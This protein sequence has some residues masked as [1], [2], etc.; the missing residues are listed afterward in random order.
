M[1]DEA[2]LIER[3][4]AGDA[5]AFEALVSPHLEVANRVAVT[6]VR[7]RVEA[8]DVVQNALIK[9]H[10][11]LTQ[12]DRSCAFRPWF[13]TITMN[14]ARNSLRAAG[15]R[16]RL[17]AKVVAQPTSQV[18]SSAEDRALQDLE[19][20]GLRAVISG[21]S[22][23]DRAVIEARFLSE[24]SEA[25]TAS[26]LGI[27]VGTV[28][29]RTS[30]AVRRLQV[31]MTLLVI[32]IVLFAIPGVRH[33]VA[34][35]LG[36]RGVRIEPQPVPTT[37]HAGTTVP[38]TGT[39]VPRAGS[40]TTGVPTTLRPLGFGSP[41]SIEAARSSVPFAF[42]VLQDVDLGAPDAV[43][44]DRSIADGV[45][46]LVWKP[47]PS[48]GIPASPALPDVG[49][50]F[51]AFRGSVD[52]A[53]FVKMLPPGTTVESVVVGGDRGFWIAGEPHQ[54][55]ASTGPG[56]YFAVETRL[57]TNTLLWQHGDVTY[58]IEADIDRERALALAGGVK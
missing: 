5:H 52:D 17:V 58:R 40:S 24:W 7:D 15:R 33:A 41:T 12:F 14:E 54:L 22:P 57:A 56:R 37:V 13:L 31:A 48:A 45:V 39:T 32:L 8:A 26:E 4:C 34:D 29:S 11:S 36:L 6:M 23:N 1:D 42:A 3:A 20:T 55:L 27:A 16:E 9:A 19:R 10:R 28:K 44:V 2:V 47:D 38:P 49:L 21:L 18:G 51:S 43:Y 30:R 25:E 50:A 46:S 35:W 53:S